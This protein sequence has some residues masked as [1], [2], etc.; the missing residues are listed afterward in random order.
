MRQRSLGLLP[1]PGIVPPAAR[2][3]V[4]PRL[5]EA[6]V[7]PRGPDVSPAQGDRGPGNA[8]SFDE[9]AGKL[10]GKGYL[11][12]AE[13]VVPLHPGVLDVEGL[14]LRGL[15]RIQ[16]A[17]EV[18]LRPLGVAGVAVALPGGRAEAPALP[19]VVPERVQREPEVRKR[20]GLGERPLPDRPGR[21]EKV[22]GRVGARGGRA[23]GVRSL[24]HDIDQAGRI[25]RI[26]AGGSDV[27]APVST[28]RVA[29]AVLEPA[30]G[31]GL[32][33]V[34][35]LAQGDQ[36]VVVVRGGRAQV[37][38]HA[39]GA[40]HLGVQ[41]ELDALVVDFP[42]VDEA[43][44]REAER[45]RDQV[46]E[47]RVARGLVVVGELD[48][49][50]VGEETR[51][52]PQ[53]EFGSD[54]RLEVGVAQVA[55]KQGGLV[56]RAG[57]RR[58]GAYRREGVGLEAGL[59]PGHAHAE[60]LGEAYIPEVRVAQHPRGAQL[61]VVDGV[62]GLAEGAVGV[63]AHRR[64]HVQLV[65]PAD[66]LLD[67]EAR[68]LGLDEVLVA[69]G[70]GGR[71]DRGNRGVGKLVSAR[72]DRETLLGEVLGP[73]GRGRCNLRSE[74]ETGRDIVVECGLKSPVIY[75]V[76][77]SL[78]EAGVREKP[79]GGHAGPEA[80]DL[81]VGEVQAGHQPVGQP[82]ERTV[83]RGDG[84]GAAVQ[85]LGEVD[86]VL[87]LG[88]TD[89]EAAG[90]GLARC[91]GAPQEHGEHPVE[92]ALSVRREPSVAA[93]EPQIRGNVEVLG[94]REPQV[95]AD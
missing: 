18:Q 51:V 75:D 65:P 39:R 41:G 67:E 82:V 48:A 57:G 22:E 60:A 31:V 69:P 90:S 85:L 23:R 40:N 64:G 62:E 37:E 86:V 53:F 94:D 19:G 55:G 58:V 25:A 4:E 77:A 17:L 76:L 89:H 87:G 11:A 16:G 54:L 93:D 8:I 74:I 1:A 3:G 47:D 33:A 68:T 72:Q 84:R 35:V 59:A 78:A 38:T 56:A 6:V 10:V 70:P 66:C 95:G 28:E 26:P 45:G 73:E 61:G 5:A 27:L 92:P 44:A 49:Q 79:S 88:R 2:L 36:Q 91:R 50:A 9:V 29:G 20:E 71:A 42:D 46:G 15:D 63:A 83:G 81:R 7:D 21:A 14:D 13:M 80:R 43:G 12:Q 52:K 32:D 30:P 34:A 24:A